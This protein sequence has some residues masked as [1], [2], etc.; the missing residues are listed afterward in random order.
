[1][2]EI[3][4]NFS[5]A[6]MNKDLDE[7]IV[8]NGQY[9]D[10]MNIQISTS[11]S[12][13]DGLGN[14]GT[15]Q[16]LK[17]NIQ[18]V[19]SSTEKVDGTSDT[20]YELLD[21]KPKVIGGVSDEA[22][23]AAYFF[24]AAPLPLDGILGIKPS[25]ISEDTLGEKIF[26][27]RIVR[28]IS[29][30]NDQVNYAQEIYEHVFIDRF[31]LM[32]S[33]SKLFNLDGNSDILNS[34]AN[35]TYFLN[36]TRSTVSDGY[37]QIKL[38]SG[39]DMNGFRVGMKMYAQS[40]GNE[41]LIDGYEENN[42]VT[43]VNVDVTGE[44]L[45][46][47]KQ[48]TTDLNTAAAF[49]FIAPRVLEFDY[50][51]EDE[52]N[53]SN[54]IPTASINILDDLLMW[55][56]GKHEPKKL[57]VKRSIAGTR[58]QPVIATDGS[59]KFSL[60]TSLYHTKLHVTD[61]RVKDLVVISDIEAVNTI[62]ANGLS[63]D[64][65]PHNITVIKKA[66]KHQVQ[67]ELVD[68][69]RAG[70][71]NFPLNNYQFV[72]DTDGDGVA[73]SK[74]KIG[75]TRN[76][77]FPSFF[78]KRLQDV[79][80]FT[81]ANTDKEIVLRGQ[82]IEIDSDNPNLVTLRILSVDKDLKVSRNP[83]DWNVELE[84]RDPIFETK[85]GRF[86]TRYL[87][88][89][90]EYSS[91]SP[92]SKLAFLPGDFSYTAEQGFNNGMR[93][94]IRSINLYNFIP[95]PYSRPLDV[96]AIDIIWKT[97]NDQNCYVV[98]TITREIDP[99]FS[100]WI[101]NGTTSTGA[102]TI[103]SEL[104]HKV[105]ESNQLLRSWDNVPRYAKAQD[106][107]SN[108]LVFG[109]YVQGY[110]I[111][112][113]VGLEQTIVSDPVLFPKPK[114]SVKSMRTYQ[115]GMV[116]GDEYGRET[117]VITNGIKTE[118]GQLLPGSSKTLKRISE[119]SNRF[120]LSQRWDGSDPSELDWIKYVKYYVKETSNEYYNLALDRWYNAGEG[121]VWLSFNSADRNKLDEETFLILKNQHSSQVPVTD[122][123][124]YKIIAISNEAP[125]FIKI[126]KRNF[127]RKQI[128]PNFVWGDDGSGG[129]VNVTDALPTA[130]ID[131]DFLEVQ[132]GVD[133][134]KYTFDGIPKVRI[135]ARYTAADGS[136]KQAVTEYK[137]VTHVD[138]T[139]NEKG[140]GIREPFTS[141]ELNLYNRILTKLDDASEFPQGTADT[142]NNSG[143]LDFK[144][145]F[146]LADFITENKSEFDGKFFVKIA[147]DA[148]L[149][150]NVLGARTGEYEVLNSFEVAFIAGFDT[151]PANEDNE[152]AS[153]MDFENASWETI[154]GIQSS[155][156][157]STI[158]QSTIG[159]DSDASDTYWSSWYNSADRTADIF[160]DEVPAFSGFNFDNFS[161]FDNQAMQYLNSGFA[162]LNGTGDDANW[163]PQGLSNGVNVDETRGQ[164][165][166]SMIHGDDDAWIGNNSY[167]KAKME[168]P[169]TLFR[170]RD[171]P[172]Q[173]VY[174]IFKITQPVDEG[175]TIEGPVQISSRNYDD[176]G[177]PDYINR[178]SLIVRF[179]LVDNNLQ[180]QGQ[181]ID[182]SIWDPQ[183]T[184]KHNGKGSLT[185][186]FVEKVSSS[187]D[188]EDA[189]VSTS[190]CFETEPK[191]DIGLDIYYEASRAFP[192]YL[193]SSTLRDYVGNNR[194]S[195]K[196]SKFTVEYRK[197]SVGD[198][199]VDVDLGD[200]CFVS[201]VIGEDTVLTRRLSG[202]DPLGVALTPINQLNSDG[203][204]VNIISPAIGDVVGF[205][206]TNGTQTRAIVDDHMKIDATAF[207]PIPSDRYTV[208]AEA[209]ASLPPNDPAVV[210]VP[211]ANWN[212]N[213]AVGME[214]TGSNIDKGTFVKAINITGGG[215]VIVVLNQEVESNSA[216]AE[217]YTF[218]EVTGNFRLD[219]KVWDRKIILG[220]NNCYSFGNGVESDRI[221]DDFNA[222][223]IDNGFKVSATF[224]NY[225]EE[226]ISS[227]MIYSGLYNSISSVNNLNE[228]N[229]AEKITKNL[230]TTYGSLQAMRARDNDVVVFTEDKVLR[231]LSSGK[232]ALF[233]ADGNAQLTATSRVLGT[234]M[235]FAGDY[236]ISK[237]PES[238]SVD[239]YRMYF[240]DKQRGAVLRLS[241]DGLTPIST[242]GMK[243]YF[244][245]NLKNHSNLVG[246][247]DGVNDEYNLMLQ[248]TRA[249]NSSSKMIT[250][251]ESSK[252]WVSFKSF[253]PIVA[254]GVGDKYYSCND[255]EIY[256]HYS[257]DV[258]RNSFYG[259]TMD[260]I[261]N[262]SAPSEIELIF[263]QGPSSIKSFKA[264]NYEGT[265]AKIDLYTGSTEQ[266]A[267]G[268]SISAND[269]EYYNL[270]A[271]KGWYVESITT[272]QQ[273]GSVNE[274]ID[275]EN[276]W[277]NYI[278]GVTTITT[279]VDTSEF[280]VQGIGF[281]LVNPTDT[282]TES[283]V[284]IQATNSEDS[285]YNSEQNKPF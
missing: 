267:A 18:Q 99:E 207:I 183:G 32:Y 144:W 11:D 25:V 35:P 68:F 227:G 66:P 205:T 70:E 79:L 249:L 278:K 252:G 49:K 118:D 276:K 246:S 101:S 162:P 78:K 45:T 33:K 235:P 275:K 279:N 217:S 94:T 260:S 212:S 139:E 131:K 223:Q 213:I 72:L 219:R 257:D 215:D 242:I 285:P 199:S 245:E 234:A 110:N 87:Y 206:D 168:T 65:L 21:N 117:P 192:M 236:G 102:L 263:N 174:E 120:K 173:S 251:N 29:A 73:D 109:N 159:T 108:R 232:D 185:I 145:F 134:E 158:E 31:G 244:R 163:A 12:G 17:G 123:S 7:R 15:V 84:R 124:K 130:L 5:G 255:D 180:Q 175:G 211:A 128:D 63:D 165:T 140:I 20:R 96:K 56:D 136:V 111:D 150:E 274:F 100:D 277:F 62:G 195:D 284:I 89:D 170:F 194:L 258:E 166:F 88:E 281:P 48:I 210:V 125:D 75:S 216:G 156:L 121:N 14:V 272:D 133:L 146:Q 226:N 71:D 283:T 250:F 186:D 60:P 47:S 167:F 153:E 91:F 179:R 262:T 4:N 254:V 41:Y 36:G 126:D 148:S 103:T 80:S 193:D 3:K 172:N 241:R 53:T 61:P 135:V 122:P 204:I 181:G 270:T 190:A 127:T 92:W 220:W 2:P 225:G 52:Y 37:D 155:D 164:L 82:I 90:N 19:L 42:F 237:N 137:T 57:N 95:Y 26:I 74:P 129:A 142:Q 83:S 208:T 177:N 24:I 229:M 240:T 188:I 64:V 157:G 200:N 228:F 266:D 147:K 30:E 224:L 187:G 67:V 43:I 239:A 271:K 201:G 176:D 196:A 202:S 149:K 222:P 152:Y 98:K 261:S 104:I 9:R 59:G 233:N 265:Q 38:L 76:V 169:G 34:I 40:T 1:M 231:V 161:S 112:S 119:F 23:N 69:D 143:S 107:T 8:P 280:T 106:I 154:G 13:I 114:P 178:N 113:K 218:I 269:Q 221:N 214:V 85:F 141:S 86:A 55:S 93:N 22:V 247:F 197:L 50:F 198:R 282:Q 28:C 273:E 191:E 253:K 256:R 46:L 171:D 132:E 10:A 81:A 105:I 44:K 268:N 27:D 182:T 238:L 243:S 58:S 115:W 16:N 138:N 259:S 6:K 203:D 184:I 97:T 264:L 116:F 54:I 230:N 160:I 151:N 209:S 248:G 39:T 77:I 51:K 189:I